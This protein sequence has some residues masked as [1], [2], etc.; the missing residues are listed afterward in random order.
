LKRREAENE[1]EKFKFKVQ[2]KDEELK[3][4]LKNNGDLIHQ[5]EKMRE[6]IR[7]FEMIIREKELLSTALT[8]QLDEL[9]NEN[10]IK[11]HDI[12]SKISQMSNEEKERQTLERREK[13]YL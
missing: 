9:R 6:E 12:K 10:K 11:E 4:E 13:S 1:I 8:R 2:M 7:S 3:R 5:I